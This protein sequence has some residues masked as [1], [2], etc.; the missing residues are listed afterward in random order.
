MADGIKDLAKAREEKLAREMTHEPAPYNPWPDV[1]SAV[2]RGATWLDQQFPHVNPGMG[3]I[4]ENM[5]WHDPQMEN[6]ERATS[7]GLMGINPGARAA[8][9]TAGMFYGRKATTANPEN[10][11]KAEDMLSRGVS[12][13]DI[14]NATPEQRL[15]YAD[16]PKDLMFERSDIESRL[17]NVGIMDY[18]KSKVSGKP[19]TV[20]DV[21]DH[22][23]LYQN[24]PH[25]ADIQLKPYLDNPRKRGWY[26]D[27][28]ANEVIGL[29]YLRP[30]YGKH[31]T[32]LHE[33]QHAIQ[34]HEGW[35]GGTSPD[36]VKAKA[37]EM[38]DFH[39]QDLADLQEAQKII[40]ETK[41]PSELWKSS[42]SYASS[43]PER[44]KEWEEATQDKINKWTK[45]HENPR[46]FYGSAI[47]EAYA[48]HG[49]ERGLIAE[50][51]WLDKSYPLEADPITGHEI[52]GYKQSWLT[53]PKDVNS[54]EASGLHD[55]YLTESERPT[56]DS[57]MQS[58]ND[59]LGK[60]SKWSLIGGA[61]AHNLT[62]DTP[63]EPSLGDM[64]ITNDGI[65]N[66]LQ[67]RR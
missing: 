21:L 25:L 60:A 29:N 44:L 40:K 23:E 57:I 22:P 10:F 6:L 56:A 52:G 7:L 61:A 27:T 39:K 26:D 8:P 66:L 30:T 64:R 49:P 19:M 41:D 15:H 16:L 5:Q 13:R 37:A 62:R 51:K 17:K 59:A 31:T 42:N 47:G 33:L 32:L 65:V 11:T 45:I 4:D 54:Y 46:T 1:Y 36:W 38:L 67:N 63:S 9:G 53:N 12:S 2:D 24:Y 43:S 18:L 3:T 28:G 20:K 35:V 58:L 55:M 14:W 34:E 48:R 50:Q